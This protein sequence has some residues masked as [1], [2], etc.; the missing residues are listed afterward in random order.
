MARD[1]VEG[2]PDL[3]GRVAIVTGAGRGL[4]LAM[5]SGLALAGCRVLGTQARNPSELLALAAFAPDRILTLRADVS[6]PGDCERLVEAALSRFGRLDILVNNAGRGMRTISE[7]FLVEPARFWQADIDAW[8][9][10]VDT[11]VNGPFFMARAAVPPMLK[12]GWG[13][14]VNISISHET[15]R[16]SGF[17]PYGPSKAALESASVIWAQDLAG[18]GVTVNVLLPGGATRTGMIPKEM[19]AQLASSLLDPAI[20]VPP[21]LYLASAR[22]DG[23]TGRR[24]VAKSWPAVE[25]AGWVLPE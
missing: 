21:L 8:R 6:D 14:I 25:A 7:R 13:R 23:V 22:S 15:M 11:N 9:A 19:P 20:V 1:A 24:F 17:S 4:G 2:D 10:I 18:T 5:A 12:A 3:V 16:R